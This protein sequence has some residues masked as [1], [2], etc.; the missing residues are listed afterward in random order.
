[1][2]MGMSV[3]DVFSLPDLWAQPPTER[4]EIE[5]IVASGSH[6]VTLVEDMGEDTMGPVLVARVDDI[7]QGSAADGRLLVGD[8]IMRMDDNQWGVKG[9][10]EVLKRLSGGSDEETASRDVKL[11]VKRLV[12]EP[13]VLIRAAPP[14]LKGSNITSTRTMPVLPV[15]PTDGIELESAAEG[16][17]DASPPLVYGLTIKTLNPADFGTM[18]WG[19]KVCVISAIAPGSIAATCRKLA[20]GDFIEAVDKK[21]AMSSSAIRS[22]LLEVEDDGKVE[23]FVTHQSFRI[24]KK[25]ALEATAWEE[26]S[27]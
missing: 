13:V 22:Q 10:D 15:N 18:P 1:M 24:N 23:I 3:L 5:V 27:C 16:A 19:G 6:G 11:F 8:H 25:E 2:G 21:E 14:P 12:H 17:P 4:L 26:C 9:V 20:V 7:E